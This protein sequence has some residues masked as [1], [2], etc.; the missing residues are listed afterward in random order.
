MKN[1]LRIMRRMIDIFFCLKKELKINSIKKR[2][3]F[4]IDSYPV[5]RKKN[6]INWFEAIDATM[7]RHRLAIKYN[8]DYPKLKEIVKPEGWLEGCPF[9]VFTAEVDCQKCLWLK[10]EKGHCYDSNYFD[11]V[12]SIERLERWKKLLKDR[13]IQ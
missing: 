13:K 3:N 1:V 11:S 2:V 5:V 10:F 7:A 8:I 9:C 12:K 6:I 4:V